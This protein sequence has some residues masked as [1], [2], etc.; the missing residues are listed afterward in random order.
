M[1]WV[2]VAPPNAGICMVR[3]LSF[4]KLLPLRLWAMRKHFCGIFALLLGEN[5]LL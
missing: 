3:R 2:L 1:E 5:A 4:E